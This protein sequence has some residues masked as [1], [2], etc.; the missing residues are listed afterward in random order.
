MRERM[1]RVVGV[2]FY[3]FSVN[4]SSGLS[5]LPPRTIRSGSKSMGNNRSGAN[6]NTFRGNR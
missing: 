1:A 2:D 6:T 3:D 5:E 4:L